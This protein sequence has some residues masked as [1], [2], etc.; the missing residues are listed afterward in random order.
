MSFRWRITLASA[1]AVAIAIL[2]TSLLNHTLTGNEL[3]NQIDA[4]LQS[5]GRGAQRLRGLLT[6][7]TRRSAIIQA[8]LPMM[9]GYQ[10]LVASDGTVIVRSAPAVTLP[11][12][13]ATLRLARHGGGPFFR[14]VRVDGIHLRVLAEPFG[15]GRAIELAQPLTETDKLLSRLMRV[16]LL[17]GLAGIALAALFGAMV[18]GAATRPL[19]RLTGRPSTSPRRG[20]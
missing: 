4:Q 19:R 8:S 11:I 17:V 9:T 1:G 2:F 14:T 18:A 7:N 16:R 3:R 15:P 12:T 5:K 6:T 20:I 13:G 10:Q